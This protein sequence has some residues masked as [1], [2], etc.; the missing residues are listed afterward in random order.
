M[1]DSDGQALCMFGILVFVAAWF[2]AICCDLFADSNSDIL[3]AGVTVKAA[4][5]ERR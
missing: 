5:E 2:V 3:R 4:E 1:N